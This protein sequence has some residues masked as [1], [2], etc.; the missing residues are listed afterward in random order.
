M[1]VGLDHIHIF[2]SNLSVTIAFFR[3]MFGATVV[4]DENAAGVRNVR[5]A[6]G[7][8][9]LHL[10]DQPS[11]APRGGPLHHIGIETD[12]LDELVSRMEEQGFHFRNKIRDE[13]KFRYVMIAGPDD[14]LIELFQCREPDRW[15]IQRL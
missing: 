13:P 8:A 1:R 9:F 15:Q 5:L 11:K 7:N 4:W 3:K 6:L 12:D 2:S 10:Y 14:L